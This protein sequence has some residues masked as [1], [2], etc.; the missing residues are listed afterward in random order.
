MLSTFN[1]AWLVTV[2]LT[3][4]S[5][6]HVACKAVSTGDVGEFGAWLASL[7]LGEYAHA[8]VKERFDTLEDVKVVTEADLVEMGL[9]RGHRRR[10]LDALKTLEVAP[11]AVQARASASAPASLPVSAADTKPAKM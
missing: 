7:S 10:L 3:L 9:A 4:L 2:L 1:F 6:H 8:F 5:P 11:T